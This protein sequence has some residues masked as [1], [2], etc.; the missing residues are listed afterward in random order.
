MVT[1][2]LDS[3]LLRM[4]RETPTQYWNDSCAVD[5]LTYAVE[6]GAT[7]ATSNPSIVL[8]VMKKEKEH[9]APRVRELAAANP[10]WSE[11]DLTWAI[12]EE[13]AARGAGILQPVFERLDGRAGR[14]SVQTNPANHRDPVRMVEQAVRFAGLAP[15][16]QVK[17]PATAA[18]VAAIE[19]ATFRGVNVNATVSFTVPQALAAAEAVERG[20]DRRAAAGGDVASMAPIVTIMIGRLDDWMKVL[21]ERDDLAVHPDAPNWAGI[22]TFKRAYG[23][24]R[25]RGYRSRMLAAAYRHR[26]HWTELVG[27]DVSMTLPY[28]W[29]VRFNRSGI[30]PE[31]RMDLPVDPS[32]LADL[33]ERIPD[34]RRAYD[35]DGMTPAEFEGYGASAR[36]LRTFVKSYHDLQGA[37]RDL[38]LPDPDIRPA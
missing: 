9:W 14:L 38:L 19:E 5:E 33:Y 12:V 2:A 29:Q 11:V 21:V 30:V 4:T 13:M 17:F 36:T 26:L 15:N 37:I 6:R 22:A 27:G 10:T 25:E 16:I 34:F 23:I 3:P 20:L 32:L 35:P 1:T 31:P 7:G 28:P 24:F 18:G 8:E